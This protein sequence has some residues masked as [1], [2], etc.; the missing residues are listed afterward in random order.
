MML[1]RG[2]WVATDKF[3]IKMFLLDLKKGV[4]GGNT[5]PKIYLV[6]LERFLRVF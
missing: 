5:P 3:L 6:A 1:I 2:L 4:V